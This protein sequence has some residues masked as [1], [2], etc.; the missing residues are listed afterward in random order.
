MSNRP[1][2]KIYV[3][4]YSVMENSVIFHNVACNC[5]RKLHL[6]TYVVLEVIFCGKTS[7]LGILIT[8]WWRATDWQEVS[9]SPAISLTPPHPH[10]STRSAALS[11]LTLTPNKLLELSMTLITQTQH[12]TTHYP[13]PKMCYI[14]SMVL[15][16]MPPSEIFLV[17]PLF[18][19]A[20][21]CGLWCGGG[22]CL[23]Q[24][25]QVYCYP[26]VTCSLPNYL[27]YVTAGCDLLR[28]IAF[29]L[30]FQS[31][32]LGARITHL[33]HRPL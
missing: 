3:Y 1:T 16:V 32:R 7:Y 2:M 29:V 26:P 25:S 22:H 24:E 5:H 33:L 15:T 8:C 27:L 10:R 13:P 18:V 21:H 31:V 9:N 14:Y 28:V 6:I 23:M 11:H 30:Q 4:M 20:H 12:K 17:F 19:A